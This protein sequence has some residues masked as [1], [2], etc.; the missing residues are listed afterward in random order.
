MGGLQIAPQ[1]YKN[2]IRQEAGHCC[3]QYT[4]SSYALSPTACTSAPTTCTGATVVKVCIV[5][6]VL[7][8]LIILSPNLLGWKL[9][10][11]QKCRLI[12]NNLVFS[13]TYFFTNNLILIENRSDK[14]RT[15]PDIC[16]EFFQFDWLLSIWTFQRYLSS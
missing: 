16:S 4:A 15:F 3:I 7:L 2:C 10:S 8:Q 11:Q 12:V 1:N 13:C 14:S 5:T 9:F 6:P